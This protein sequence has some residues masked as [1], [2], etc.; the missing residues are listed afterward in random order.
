MLAGIKG[1][2]SFSYSVFDI[3][4]ERNLFASSVLLQI[5]RLKTGKINA[6][7]NDLLLYLGQSSDYGQKTKNNSFIDENYWW[8]CKLI[9]EER[10]K[11]ARLSVLNI[12]PWLKDGSTAIKSRNSSKLTIYDGWLNPK[13]EDLDPRKNKNFVLACTSIEFYAQSPYAFFLK[14]ILKIE[15]PEEIKKDLTLWLDSK[16]RG[17]LLHEI[18]QLFI[19]KLI[20]MESYPDIESQ[21]KIMNKVLA[22]AIEKYKDEIPFPSKAVF[23]RE[24]NKLKKDVNVFIDVNA[25][26]GIPQLLEYEFGYNNEEPVRISI[27]NNTHIYIKGKIDRVD[28]DK[29]L[30]DTFHVWDYKTGSL[31]GYEEG[32]YVNKGK[33]IQH[34]LYAKVVEE[35]LKNKNPN[36]RVSKCGY[37][38]PTQKG[39]DSGKGCILARNPYEDEKWQEALSC[40]LDLIANGI[41]I[42]SEEEN[43]PYID[44]E[45]IYGTKTNKKNISEKIKDSEN[46]VLEKLKRLREF[47]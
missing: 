45:D 20:S 43:P 7:Y 1:R 8:L 40:I 32:G 4:D 25:K 9:S 28:M 46:L 10:L 27:G 29:D 19:K 16:S 41:F 37:I 2:I 31:Y 42:Y 17:S 39:R 5:Y 3:K 33:Q 44:D 30:S 13:S 35:L 11:D 36:Y 24:V 47:K 14:H 6:D 22:D 18:F 21:R 38:F 12:Y 15:R 34:V 23:T 26:L